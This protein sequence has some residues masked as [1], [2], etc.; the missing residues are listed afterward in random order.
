MFPELTSGIGFLK[1]YYDYD[2]LHFPLVLPVGTLNNPG[3]KISRISSFTLSGCKKILL[4]F[5]SFT[6]WGKGSSPSGPWQ[7]DSATWITPPLMLLLSYS[8][9]LDR[10]KMLCFSSQISLMNLPN[11]CLHVL[12]KLD[13]RSTYTVAIVDYHSAGTGKRSEAC[14]TI[15]KPPYKC[16]GLPFLLLET[17]ICKGTCW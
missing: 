15:S 13:E 16:Q 4:T 14:S 1:K 6:S 11:T 17:P 10:W 5:D 12:H 8:V 9:S 3:K 2:L 7:V